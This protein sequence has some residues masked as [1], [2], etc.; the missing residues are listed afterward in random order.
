MVSF[1]FPV[2][3]YS[4]RQMKNETTQTLGVVSPH[5]PGE[6]FR[7]IFS[8]F[9]SLL[10]NFSRLFPRSQSFLVNFNRFSLVFSQF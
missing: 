2:G 4:A 7:A 5:L 9:Q 6:I 8:H 1:F 3:G 10:V